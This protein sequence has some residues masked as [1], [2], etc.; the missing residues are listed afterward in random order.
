MCIFVYCFKCFHF[1]SDTN[2]QQMA[3]KHLC[4]RCH[5][6]SRFL[7]TRKKFVNDIL[8]YS[9]EEDIMCSLSDCRQEMWKC[10]VSWCVSVG[11]PGQGS[12]HEAR[13]EQGKGGGG[14]DQRRGC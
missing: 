13:K 4:S 9:E 12:G 14:Q 10:S 6:Y 1:E 7:K 5:T 8:V 2:I 3:R 11:T